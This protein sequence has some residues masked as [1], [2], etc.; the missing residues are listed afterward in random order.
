MREVNLAKGDASLHLN[1]ATFVVKVMS[2]LRR[3]SLGDDEKR[4]L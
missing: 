2:V 1:G 4:S 3:V